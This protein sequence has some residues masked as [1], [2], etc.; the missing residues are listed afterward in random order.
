MIT[1]AIDGLK[2]DMPVLMYYNGGLENTEIGIKNSASTAQIILD[3][4]NGEKSEKPKRT[5]TQRYLGIGCALSASVSF[6]LGALLVKLMP[7]YH[8]F[9]VSFWRFFVGI[10]VPMVPTALFCRFVLK[11]AIFDSLF[12]ISEPGKPKTWILMCVSGFNRNIVLQFI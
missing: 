4:N 10:L 12:P 2:N 8:P 7:M 9:S 6:S 1:K 11:M 3:N 5:G